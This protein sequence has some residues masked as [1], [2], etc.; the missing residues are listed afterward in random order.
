MA[1]KRPIFHSEAD[2]Q[3]TLAWQIHTQ[4]PDARIRLETRPGADIRLDLLVTIDGHRTAIELKY[5][6]ARF[7][8]IVDGSASSCRRG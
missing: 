4:H 8:G 1:V 5:I 2:L 3:R 6:K 7:D